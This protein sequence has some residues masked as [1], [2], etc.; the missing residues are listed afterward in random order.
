MRTGG[1]SEIGAALRAAR[2]RTLLLADAYAA[3]LAPG[4][5]AVPYRATLNP[6][7]WEWGHV[8]WFQEWWVGRNRQRARGVACEPEHDRAPS[9]LRTADDKRT[10]GRVP[11]TDGKTLSHLLN[12]D[13]T[14]VGSLGHIVTA[15]D[16]MLEWRVA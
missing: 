11:A 9:M 6:P 1:R 16:G 14:P 4:G 12:M 2:K 8:A 5:Y 3:E 10:L 7:L 15:D 13:R